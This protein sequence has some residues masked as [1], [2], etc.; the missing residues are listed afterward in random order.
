MGEGGGSVVEEGWTIGGGGRVEES[1]GEVEG[2]GGMEV[3]GCVGTYFLT[4]SSVLAVL[5]PPRVGA[6]G[7]HRCDTGHH[8]IL[9]PEPHTQPGGRPY[10]VGEGIS[11]TAPR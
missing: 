6:A 10:P 11:S 5:P 1:G 8:L 7:E 3:G 2:L 9:P 4:H